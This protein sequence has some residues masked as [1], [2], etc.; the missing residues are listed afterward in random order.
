[1]LFITAGKKIP[2]QKGERNRQSSRGRTDMRKIE[3]NDAVE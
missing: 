1:M 3:R 2:E